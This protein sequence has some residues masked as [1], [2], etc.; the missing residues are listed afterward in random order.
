MDEL[1]RVL[2]QAFKA[3]GKA[4]LTRS[5]LAFALSLDLKWFTPDE[6]REA[7]DAG[8][9]AGLLTETDGKITP[10]FD[11]KTIDIPEGFHPG[12]DLFK[13]ALL[14]RIEILLVNSGIEAQAIKSIL[15]KK[16]R[17]LCDLVTPEVAGLVLAKDRGLDIS[18]YIDE[19]LR[20]VM[21]T[22]RA[23]KF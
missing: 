6:S 16:Q 11:Y 23:G 10:S 5:E 20:Q 1:K 14:E 17:E 22:T 19:A 8:L 4:R 15:G 13:K 7:V 18:D 9:Q 3:R 2:A 12:K 21:N